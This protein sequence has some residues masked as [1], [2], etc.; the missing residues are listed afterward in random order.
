M[1]YATRNALVKGLETVILYYSLLHELKS[2][3]CS[4]F[5]LELLANESNNPNNTS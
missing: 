2:V 1:L 4:Y 5:D 3:W